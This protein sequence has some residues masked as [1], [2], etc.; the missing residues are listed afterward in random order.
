MVAVLIHLVVL[1]TGRIHLEL[2]CVTLQGGIK[3]LLAMLLNVGKLCRVV[4]PGLP[5]TQWMKL[6]V[7]ASS[8]HGGEPFASRIHIIINVILMRIERPQGRYYNTE[9]PQGR[10]IVPW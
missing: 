2:V 4:A 10:Y 7:I 8:E 9:R 6:P 5:D 1:L 3:P